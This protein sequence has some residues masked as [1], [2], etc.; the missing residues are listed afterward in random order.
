MI[1]DVSNLHITKSINNALISNSIN[2]ES[3]KGFELFVRFLEYWV[4]QKKCYFRD[5]STS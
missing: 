4:S 1:G 5:M 3:N 2:L